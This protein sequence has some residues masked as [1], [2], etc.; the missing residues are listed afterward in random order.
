MGSLYSLPGG[1]KVGGLA[2]SIE[3]FN[4]TDGVGFQLGLSV[5]SLDGRCTEPDSATY[6]ML[7]GARGARRFPE[8]QVFQVT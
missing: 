3:D 2:C 7:P 8:I 1:R 4:L 6:S 5:Q